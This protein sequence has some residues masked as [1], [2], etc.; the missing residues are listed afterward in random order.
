MPSSRSV[1]A[2][3]PGSIAHKLMLG[4]AVIALLC[5]G[6]TAFLIYRQASASLVNA[7]RQTMASE[8]TA[9]ARQVAADL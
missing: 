4:T 2:R 6:L 1:A 8:A 9:E 5:F 3:R 7:S